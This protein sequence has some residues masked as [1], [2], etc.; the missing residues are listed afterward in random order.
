MKSG[1]AL[2]QN[3]HHDRSITIYSVPLVGE[4]DT[5]LAFFLSHLIQGV[6]EVCHNRFVWELHLLE[7]G[8]WI[9]QFPLVLGAN[10]NLT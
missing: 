10:S 2:Q 5:T 3:Q 4:V 7:L 6:N 1:L 9:P 8:F